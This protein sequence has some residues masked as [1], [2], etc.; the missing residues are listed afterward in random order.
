[1]TVASK[2][3][4]AVAQAE[5]LQS[6]LKTFALDTQNKEAKQVYQN[7]A[8]QMETITQQLQGRLNFIQSEEPQFRQ[9]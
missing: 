1:M 7:L 6:Q 2:M 8:R 3:K 5:S 4:Q 9:S